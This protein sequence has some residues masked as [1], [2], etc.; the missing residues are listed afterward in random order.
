MRYLENHFYSVCQGNLLKHQAMA[1][2]CNVKRS[3][4]LFIEKPDCIINKV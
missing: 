4:Y 1:T 3:V 2:W